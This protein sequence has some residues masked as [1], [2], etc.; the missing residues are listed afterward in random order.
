MRQNRVYDFKIRCMIRAADRVI[1][2]FHTTQWVLNKRGTQGWNRE[3]ISL[4]G[5]CILES[6]LACLLRKR[7]SRLKGEGEY[8]QASR[9]ADLRER[10]RGQMDLRISGRRK[11]ALGGRFHS[12]RGVG[13]GG[14]G[15]GLINHVDCFQGWTIVSRERQGMMLRILWGWR[16]CW[17]FI[18]GYERTAVKTFSKAEII[19]GLQLPEGNSEWVLQKAALAL[20]F[21]GGLQCAE[22]IEMWWFGWERWQDM[23][24]L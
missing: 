6:V 7:G 14:E 24:S 4:L 9:W 8:T 5:G 19:S 12:V 21:C 3:E 22:G 2:C 18:E 16:C 17:R 20:A 23:G 1:K 15:L 13:E 11:Q 10:L